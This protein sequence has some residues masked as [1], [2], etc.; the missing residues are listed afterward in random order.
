MAKFSLALALNELHV[1]PSN[2]ETME[3]I[4]LAIDVDRDGLIDLDEFVAAALA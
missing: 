1:G 3:E 4:C 2:G